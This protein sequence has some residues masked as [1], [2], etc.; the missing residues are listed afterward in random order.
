MLN[1]RIVS[2]YEENNTL[3]VGRGCFI[4][5]I[6]IGRHSMMFM[7]VFF[8]I[9]RGSL[10]PFG[11]LCLTCAVSTDKKWIFIVFVCFSL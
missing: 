10:G 8:S 3:G 11:A 2:R 6:T 4:T 7:F 1:K 9:Y 5:L